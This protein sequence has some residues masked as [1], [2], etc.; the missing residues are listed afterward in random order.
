ML[1]ERGDGS[2]ADVL[3]YEAKVIEPMLSMHRDLHHLADRVRVRVRVRVRL[4]LRLRVLVRLA[5][6]APTPE[7]PDPMLKMAHSP[8]YRP[9]KAS[10]AG[11]WR[12][13]P[14]KSELWRRESALA[15]GAKCWVSASPTAF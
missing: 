7:T 10:D 2:L 1:A 14:R 12:L 6:D 9:A 11:L 4:R 15:D 5:Q 3:A 8:L 13:A